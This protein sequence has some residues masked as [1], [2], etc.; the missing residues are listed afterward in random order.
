MSIFEHEYT[1]TPLHQG[2]YVRW[3]ISYAVFAADE[4]GT[5][6][7]TEPIYCYGLII[8]VANDGTPS[9]VVYIPR[10]SEYH[11]IDPTKYQFEVLSSAKRSP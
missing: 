1:G 5:A 2:D 3:V 11:T 6:W 8:E 4:I 10:S 9:I 7:P